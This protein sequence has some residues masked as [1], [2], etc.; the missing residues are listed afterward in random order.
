MTKTIDAKKLSR[1]LEKHS[2]KNKTFI[3]LD[4]RNV[5][6]FLT[7][8]QRSRHVEIMGLSGSGKSSSIILPMIFQDICA[9]KSV[10]CMDGKGEIQ[11]MQQILASLLVKEDFKR[12]ALGPGKKVPFYYLNPAKPDL[13]CTYNPVHTGPNTDLLLMT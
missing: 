3:G 9:E 1:I 4:G 11:F 5:P 13:S 2:F 10:V 12:E 6:K 8:S 7:E